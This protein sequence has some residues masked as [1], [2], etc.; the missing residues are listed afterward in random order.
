MNSSTSRGLMF[1]PRRIP[2][3]LLLPTMLRLAPARVEALPAAEAHVLAPSDDAAV[4]VLAYP[5]QVARVHPAGGVD[6]LGSLLRVLPVA[7]HHGVAAG[8]ELSGL[9]TR[10]H[11]ACLRVDH[12]DLDVRHRP[13]DSL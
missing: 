8:A 10:H 11:Q 1:S 12:L 5:R 13:A 2:M 4:A 7:E 9:A 3:P 6:R